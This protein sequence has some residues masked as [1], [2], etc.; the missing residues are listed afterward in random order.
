M[1][2]KSKKPKL[3]TLE[4]W[5]EEFAHKAAMDVYQ[6][7][8]DERDKV[9]SENY[10]VMTAT[11]IAGLLSALVFRSLAFVP[12]KLKSDKDKCDYAE[13]S[14][15]DLKIRIQEAV[16]AG[17]AGGMKTWSGKNVDYYCQVKVM[18][19]PANMEHPC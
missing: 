16:A 2:S 6:L 3:K 5:C 10:K 7:F 14:F 8:E 13:Q 18:P 9:G 15:A 19:E 11:F 12:E 4:E 1:K 17:F